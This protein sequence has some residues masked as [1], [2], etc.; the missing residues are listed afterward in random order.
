MDGNCLRHKIN[1]EAGKV[2]KR[3]V[4]LPLR[5]DGNGWKGTVEKE[6]KMK[7]VNQKG[8]DSLQW[9]LP[10]KEKCNCEKR[11]KK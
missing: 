2:D 8:E 1:E 3:I 11:D 7:K 5:D 6:K 10:W 4:L 9:T